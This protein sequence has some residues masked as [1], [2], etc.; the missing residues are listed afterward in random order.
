MSML[1]KPRVPSAA[2]GLALSLLAALPAPGAAQMDHAAH[3]AAVLM[4]DL[5]EDVRTVRGKLVALA[6]AIPADR[7]GWAPGEGVRSV[8]QTLLHV[9]ADNYFIPV[10]A[11]TMAPASTGIVGD[12]VQA[13]YRGVQAYEARELD[14]DAVIRELNASFDH[15]AG[16]MEAEG[17]ARLP[18]SLDLFGSESTH[19]KLWILTT[20]HLH[21]HL[22]QMIAYARSNGVVPPWS[23]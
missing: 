12:D 14:K 11:G 17:D 7:Y 1:T 5:V 10:A 15:L 19:Q 20:T 22:G 3:H 16:I 9:A 21:E 8:R 4:P 2:A 23:R 13:M 18:E 6:E